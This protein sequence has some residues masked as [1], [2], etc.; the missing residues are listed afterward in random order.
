MLTERGL[1]RLRWHFDAKTGGQ[2]ARWQ[3]WDKAIQPMKIITIK[4]YEMCS[5]SRW[6]W[7]TFRAGKNHAGKVIG[8]RFLGIGILRTE[9]LRQRPPG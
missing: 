1:L 3:Q 9:N 4:P 6:G 2:K 5:P 8:F 7:H